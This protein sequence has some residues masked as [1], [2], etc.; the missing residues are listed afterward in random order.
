MA[1]M[2]KNGIMTEVPD[3]TP[4]EIAAIDAERKAYEASPEY[5][6]R[7]I[8]EFKSKLSATD[9]KAIKFAEGWMTEEEFAPIRAERQRIREQINALEAEL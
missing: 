4:E 1:K 3:P 5:K 7:K 9:Y 6:V 2:W 8:A